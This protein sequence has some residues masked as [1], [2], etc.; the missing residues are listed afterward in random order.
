MP[1]VLARRSGRDVRKLIG[2]PRTTTTCAR[3]LLPFG[4]EFAADSSLRNPEAVE[5]GVSYQTAGSRARLGNAV[6]RHR[7]ATVREWSR[8][9]NELRP[10]S[11]AILNRGDDYRSSEPGA[12]A[13]K[14]NAA[15]PPCAGEADL[16]Y[17]C[18]NRS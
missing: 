13:T 12:S 5:N 3:P 11:P 2:E 10:F 6:R 18:E 16:G 14:S 15:L 4:D 9:R 17:S 1:L 7:A 8:T